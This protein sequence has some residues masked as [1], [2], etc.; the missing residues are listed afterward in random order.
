MQITVRMPGEYRDKLDRLS[1]SMGVR[2]SDVIRLA[3]KQFFEDTHEFS[4]KQPY[5]KVDRLL[6]IVESGVKDLGQSHRSYII[7][8]LR[9]GSGS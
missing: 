5:S 4:R 8:K 7:K 9:K 3:M 6:G 1:K 2:R